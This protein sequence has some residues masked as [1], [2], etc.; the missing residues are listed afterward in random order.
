MVNKKSLL[1]KKV[2][3]ITGGARGIGRATVNKFLNESS[4]NT[5]IIIDKDMAACKKFQE[6]ENL[7]IYN[8][9]ITC[10]EQMELIINEIFKKY[11]NIDVLINNAAIQT[12]KNILKIDLEDWK[13][14]I[15]VNING[16]F[17]ISKIVAKKMKSNSTILN[18]ISTHYNK[19][20]RDKLHYDISKAGVAMMTKG[21]ALELSKRNIT[22]NALA[23]GATYTSMNEIFK[24]NKVAE[25]LAKSKVPLKKIYKSDEIAEYIYNIINNFSKATTGSIF[26]IDGG[27]NLV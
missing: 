23:I 4:E 17:I 24:I 6:R 12:T 14:V 10:Y 15:E 21:F 5:V 20:R 26:T 27:R 3:L 13:N 25:F 9:D 19:P 16:T 8:C 1:K 18:I 22:V 7:V 11:G 2:V